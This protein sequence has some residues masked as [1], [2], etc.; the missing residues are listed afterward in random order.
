MF[1][2]VEDIAYFKPVELFTK[3]GR[4]GKIKEALGTHG[5]M[6]CYFNDFM[7]A[8]DTVCLPLYKRV[9]PM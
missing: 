4:R 2:N 3:Y 5:L 7:K 6:K 9:Y 8:D 1:F